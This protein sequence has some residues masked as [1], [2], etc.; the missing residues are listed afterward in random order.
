MDERE[1]HVDDA[2][3]RCM[4]PGVSCAFAIDQW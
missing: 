2:V 1:E 3:V 4:K